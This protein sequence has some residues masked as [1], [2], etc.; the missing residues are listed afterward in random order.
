MLGAANGKPQARMTACISGWPANAANCRAARRD[1]VRTSPI[2]A[3]QS[4]WLADRHFSYRTG[5]P[6]A[7]AGHLWLAT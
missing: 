3:D 5:A 1:D 4:Q 7:S 2:A 6:R